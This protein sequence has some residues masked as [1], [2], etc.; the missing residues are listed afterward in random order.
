MSVAAL[1]ERDHLL[2]VRAHGFRLGL[3]SLDAIFKNQRGHQVAQRRAPVR[4]VTSEFPSCFAVTHFLSFST[5]YPVL[6]THLWLRPAVAEFFFA[7]QQQVPR[8]ARNDNFK[9]PE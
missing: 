1:A 4:G 6:S 9:K 5:E 3:R 2:D 7:E 8:R